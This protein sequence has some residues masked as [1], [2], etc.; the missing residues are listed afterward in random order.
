MITLNRVGNNDESNESQ[1]FN[2]PKNSSVDIT[3]LC[4]YMGENGII[5]YR[6][7]EFGANSTFWTVTDSGE[8]DHPCRL[9]GFESKEKWIMPVSIYDA[10]TKSWSE[11]KYYRFPKTVLDAMRDVNA[12]IQEFSDSESEPKFKF[13]HSILK[14]NRDDNTP[15]GFTKYSVNWTGRHLS[16]SMKNLP[17]NTLDM[18]KGVY[19]ISEDDANK[20]HEKC[21]ERLM[22]KS[23]FEVDGK[24]IGERLE[25]LNLA[26]ETPESEFE[27][28][29]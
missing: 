18:F 17:E 13:K 16:K 27:I 10:A 8:L 20:F 28:V 9:M 1:W 24:I 19:G 3:P 26:K 2:V 12:T 4:D 6:Q 29:E 7:F 5:K 11:P 25:E 15:N 22:Q 21:L 23:N 14:I